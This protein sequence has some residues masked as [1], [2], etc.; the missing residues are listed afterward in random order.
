MKY[1][2]SV[3]EESLR[4]GLDAIPELSDVPD[5]SL[6]VLEHVKG[7]RAADTVAGIAVQYAAFDFISAESR[8]ETF[9]MVRDPVLCEYS[10]GLGAV[11]DADMGDIHAYVTG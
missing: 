11:S 8:A 4:E 2:I 7:E 6:H 9:V 10:G 3:A 5:V 1:D